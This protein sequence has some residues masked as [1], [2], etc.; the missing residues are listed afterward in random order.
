MILIG[1]LIE[2]LLNNINLLTCRTAPNLNLQTRHG[3]G[4]AQVLTVCLQRTCHRYMRWMIRFHHQP[5]TPSS[6]SHCSCYCFLLH[7][8][9]CLPDHTWVHQARSNRLT[10]PIYG[11]DPHRFPGGYSRAGPL[12]ICGA[13]RRPGPT[14]RRRSRCARRRGL[15]RRGSGGRGP[16]TRPRP[17]A[18]GSARPSGGKI[19]QAV[20]GSRQ[21]GCSTHQGQGG[22]GERKVLLDRVQWK[23]LRWHT[24]RTM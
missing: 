12:K 10:E 8:L 7:Y 1:I 23:T 3:M 6:S 22:P 4:G 17:R 16:W 14:P 2:T 20:E 21:S 24:R 9:I 5:Q 13:H 11:R 19:P 15:P 18:G